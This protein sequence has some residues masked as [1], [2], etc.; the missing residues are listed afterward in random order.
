MQ[1]ERQ[2][3]SAWSSVSE[4]SGK[5]QTPYLE[6]GHELWG[7][8][9]KLIFLHISMVLLTLP[10]EKPYENNCRMKREYWRTNKREVLLQNIYGIGKGRQLQHKEITGN[11]TKIYPDILRLLSLWERQHQPVPRTPE[12]VAKNFCLNRLEM[13][14]PDCFLRTLNPHTHFQNWTDMCG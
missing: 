9:P 13:L 14:Q 11:W 4:F 3:P 1:E 12:I 5:K 6:M 8:K 10:Y 2:P 7:Q